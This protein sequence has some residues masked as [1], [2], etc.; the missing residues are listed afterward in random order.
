M[1]ATINPKYRNG[2][3]NLIKKLKA[4]FYKFFGTKESIK[5][6]IEKTII[7]LIIG[8]VSLIIEWII[9]GQIGMIT[10][11]VGGICL[12]FFGYKW[13]IPVTSIIATVGDS[14]SGNNFILKWMTII[15]SIVFGSIAGYIIF[16]I[17][18]IRL[19]FSLGKKDIDFNQ[20]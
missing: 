11:V 9:G 1:Y 20:N 7:F 18:L 13:A 3:N 16:V 19:F 8:V 4:S 2:E 17:A 5:V 15:L 6:L 14:L 12:I 10:Q